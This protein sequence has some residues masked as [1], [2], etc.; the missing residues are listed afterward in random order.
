MLPIACQLL[1]SRAVRVRPQHPPHF[2]LTTARV[3]SH[4]V[5]MPWRTKGG[6]EV[7][8]G[9]R[10]LGDKG[11]VFEGKCVLLVW[12]LTNL[13]FGIFFNLLSLP[14]LSPT[15]SSLSL[16]KVI[17]RKRH[18]STYRECRIEK[19]PPRVSPWATGCWK[20]SAGMGS[21]PGTP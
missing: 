1:P 3:V 17:I 15:G 7:T 6:V 14:S 12:L 5:G 13:L 20:K 9:R 21:C 11:F 18:F 19:T 10:C 16:E 8:E 2:G 4:Q